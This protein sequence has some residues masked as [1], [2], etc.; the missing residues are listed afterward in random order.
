MGGAPSPQTQ[1]FNLWGL[2]FW[3]LSFGVYGLKN[4]DPGR[5]RGLGLSMR[6]GFRFWV[7]YRMEVRASKP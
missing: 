7:D 6:L 4:S 3:G 2:G 5:A 1:R